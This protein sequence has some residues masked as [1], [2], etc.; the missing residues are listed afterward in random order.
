MPAAVKWVVSKI[1]IWFG[2]NDTQS[3]I[4]RIDPRR[5]RGNWRKRRSAASSTRST[6]AGDTPHPAQ[7]GAPVAMALAV[8]PVD[9]A[10]LV[11]QRQNLRA[12]PV[13]QRVHR[14]PARVSSSRPAPRASHR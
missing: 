4:N 1:Q 12:F 7:I 5:G 6:V 9:L 11:E 10:P 2:R 3:G 13:Q 14:V 8:G